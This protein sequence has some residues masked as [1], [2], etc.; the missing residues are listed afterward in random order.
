MKMSDRRDSH[1]KFGGFDEEGA[2]N[3]VTG[4]PDFKFIRT[5]AKDTWRLKMRSAGLFMNRLNFEDFRVIYTAEYIFLLNSRVWRAFK[6][7]MMDLKTGPKK[8]AELMLKHPAGFMLLKACA[9]HKRQ[10]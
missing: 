10:R 6:I 9:C 1:I 7:I 2:L 4:N 5:T 8:S 3:S